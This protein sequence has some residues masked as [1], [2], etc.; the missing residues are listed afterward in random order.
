MI[1]VRVCN[2]DLCVAILLR[3]LANLTWDKGD[4]QINENVNGGLEFS[5][6][7]IHVPLQ[8][9]QNCV[10]WIYTCIYYLVLLESLFKSDKASHDKH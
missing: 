6:E 3:N 8:W 7:L 9:A 5:L 2:N 4:C 1:L 10:Y